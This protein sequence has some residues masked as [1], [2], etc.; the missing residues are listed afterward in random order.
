MLTSLILTLQSPTE[1]RLPASLGR[2]G[3][4]LLLRLMAERDPAAAEALH[5]GDGLRPYTVSNLVMGKRTKGSLQ[6]AAGQAG[7]LRFTGLTAEVSG[8]LQALAANP[9]EQVELDG[10][11]FRV[12]GATLDPAGQPWAG[13][14]S[15]QDLAAPFLLGGESRPAAKIGLEFAGPTTFRSKGRYLPLPLPELIFGSLLD[16][17]QAFAPIA[18][19]PEVRRFAE[20][21]VVLSR[22]RLRSRG[23]PYKQQGMQIG[24]TGRATFAALNRDRYWLNVLHLLAAFSFYSGVGYGTAAGLGQTRPF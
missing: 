12:V 6:L 4:A 2:A 11:Q 15:Y 24:F 5:Q 8:Q 9:P 16:R 14:V 10:H 18:L 3:Q 19:H 20:E 13:Q 23:L 1:G 17:W 7:W 22:Y 21:A